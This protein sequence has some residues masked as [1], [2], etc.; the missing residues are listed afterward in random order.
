MDGKYEIEKLPLASQ[1]SYLIL[2]PLI[3]VKVCKVNVPLSKY[4][5][6]SVEKN[7]RRIF[8]AFPHLSQ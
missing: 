6:A 7:F 8:N 2:F 1:S 3:H 4:R 5:V